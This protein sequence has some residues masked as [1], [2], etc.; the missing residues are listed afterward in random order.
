MFFSPEDVRDPTGFNLGIPVENNPP[1]PMGPPLLGL[2]PLFAT[3]ELFSLLCKEE[4]P[5]SPLTLPEITT[6]TAMAGLLFA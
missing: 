4:F 2:M 3:L 6:T 5:G 1:N